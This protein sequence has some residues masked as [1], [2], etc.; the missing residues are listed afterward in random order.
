MLRHHYEILKTVCEVQMCVP[1]VATKMFATYT[2]FSRYAIGPS[3]TKLCNQG[4]AQ[5]TQ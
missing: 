2:E 3:A 5:C 4:T 1:T